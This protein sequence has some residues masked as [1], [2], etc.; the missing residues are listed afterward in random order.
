MGLV[1]AMQSNGPLPQVNLDRTRATKLDGLEEGV[2][3]VE[4]SSKSFQI[5]ILVEG[6][7]QKCTV[8]QYQ[9]P[10]TAAHGFTDY[11]SQE[12]TIPYVLVDI[13][14]PLTGT[15]SL[16]NLYI[17]LSRSS[18]QSTIRLLWDFN[19]KLFQSSHDTWL[20]DEDYRLDR[21]DQITKD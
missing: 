18:G 21:L 11:Q 20:L 16:F 12:Q 9:F 17:A 14:S 13:T 19:E 5:S 7:Y 6:K 8:H 4:V 2:I 3:P 15:L 10:M 1:H